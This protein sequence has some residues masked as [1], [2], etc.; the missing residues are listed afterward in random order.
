MAYITGG[1][2]VPNFSLAEMTN[3]QADEK[4][5]LILTP[6]VVE[7]AQM[8]Q[9][10]RDWCGVPLTVSSWFRTKAFNK[11]CGG[12]SNSAHLDGRAT[13]IKGI[14]EELY[15]DFVVAWQTICSTH[16]KIGGC[17]LY[18]WGIHFDSYSDK[19]GYDKFRLKDNR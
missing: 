4:V 1:R 17:E 2:L 6:E 16:G 5:K 3:K 7:H 11:K 12:A 13:D 10:L 8:M 14:P 19:F 18:P 9:E 15:H